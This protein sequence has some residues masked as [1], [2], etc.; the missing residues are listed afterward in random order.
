MN[1][2]FK[3]YKIIFFILLFLIPIILIIIENKEV[4]NDFWFLVNTG[5]YIVKNDLPHIDPFTFHEGLKLVTQQWL[6]DIIFYF[7]Y[8]NFGKYGML[9]LVI[10][11]SIIN[12]LLIYKTSYL[13][14]K[15]KTL[16]I[17]ISVVSM[18]LLRGFFVTRPQIITYTLLNLEL[19]Q[20]EKFI[21][22]KEIKHLYILPIISLLEINTISLYVISQMEIW[23]DTQE[24]WKLHKKQ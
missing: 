19:L 5:K 7:T 4:N 1:N 11:I 23:L 10:I 13:L 17:L 22:T 15:N 24:S 3:K 12:E 21:Q 14:S 16:S 9:S 6:T 20:L 18:S 2:F 8:S